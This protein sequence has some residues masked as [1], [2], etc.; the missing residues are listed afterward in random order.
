MQ[1]RTKES[2]DHTPTSR[3]QMT[4][5]EDFATNQSLEMAFESGPGEKTATFFDPPPAPVPPDPNQA[6]FLGL[7]PVESA[8]SGSVAQEN[9]DAPPDAQA[10]HRRQRLKSA[11]AVARSGATDI[12]T[13]A[14]ED[15]TTRPDL[16]QHRDVNPGDSVDPRRVQEII[17]NW[18]PDRFDPITLVNDGQGGFIVL[19]GHHRL[20]AMQRMGETAI[21]ARLVQGEMTNEADRKRLIQEAVVSNFN[22]AESNLR[23]R[24]SAANSLAESGWSRDEIAANMRLKGRGEAERLLW[25]HA[26]G[27]TILARVTLQTEL[28]PAG[29]EL[30]RAIKER[31]LS[32]EAAQGLFS[33]WM[34]DYE[35]TDRVPGHR[36][37]RRQIDLLSG[38]ADA[39]PT[40]QAGMLEGFEGDVHLNEFD[41]H[42][43]DLA[44]LTEEANRN[45]SRVTSCEA[46]AAELGVDISRLQRAAAIRGKYLTQAQEEKAR[47]VLGLPPLPVQVRPRQM[48]PKKP[49]VVVAK[50]AVT[51]VQSAKATRSK[52]SHPEPPPKAKIGTKAYAAVDAVG[53]ANEKEYGALQNV[54]GTRKPSKG[55]SYAAVDAAK[56]VKAA[57]VGK[58][59]PK[60]GKMGPP[61][62]CDV[63]CVAVKGG[64]QAIEALSGTVGGEGDILV[65]PQR[66][67]SLT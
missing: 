45:H 51:P 44:D 27:P 49:P 14:I 56:N 22:V 58:V 48:A 25:L 21:P 29:I 6:S 63:P 19:A 35:E 50:R 28:A 2:T 20:A 7:A 4:L 30:G 23:E 37:L 57:P 34:R 43:R 13:I 60:R 67:R 26:S 66:R 15:I 62:A 16:F 42:R 24:A 46:L 52:G 31:G 17:A 59:T 53:K 5:G 55:T 32:L 40:A 47:L 39:N 33:R 65:S 54:P 10:T 3:Q 1:Q 11:P 18:N 41:Q 8:P 38:L 12:Q 64:K 61:E 9:V 36:S